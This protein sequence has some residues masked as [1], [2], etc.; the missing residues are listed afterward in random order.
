M[1]DRKDRN[2]LVI[3]INR[4]L[5]EEISAFHFDDEIFA[6]CDRTE[7]PTV[8]SIVQTLWLFYDD[9]KDHKVV[10]SKLGWDFFQ[11]ALLVLQSDGE[12]EETRQSQW[13]VRQAIAGAGLV[14]FGV[15]VLAVGVGYH[16]FLVC[17]PFGVISMVLARWHA[18]AEEEQLRDS[19]TAFPF[20][21]ISET[22]AVRRT[23]KDFS[24]ARYPERLRDR[25]IRSRLMDHIVTLPAS[26]LWL[27]FGP[28]G[29]L[30]QLFPEGRSHC[31]VVMP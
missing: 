3:A 5:G 11:R 19:W 30:L 26:I 4:Y 24:K 18:R 13:T 7:D 10:A 8:Q 29:L 17:V 21:S 2:D 25:T 23:V 31:R 22:L 20:S 6:I 27:L 9:C 15:A 16:V 28:I 12:I 1:V 14:P